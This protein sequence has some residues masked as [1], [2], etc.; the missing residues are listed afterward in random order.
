MSSAYDNI[1]VPQV[2]ATVINNLANLTHGEQSF[3]VSLLDQLSYRDLSDKRLWA[4]DALA[5]KSICNSTPTSPLE[6]A[7]HPCAR[8]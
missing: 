3:A 2:M 6:G 5:K 1:D 8:R 4:L 7:R